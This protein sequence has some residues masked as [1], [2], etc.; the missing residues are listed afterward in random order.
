MKKQP[1]NALA[2]GLA[3]GLAAAALIS[4]SPSSPPPP[5]SPPAAAEGPR[6]VTSDSTLGKGAPAFELELLDGGRLSLAEHKG[7]HTVILDFW[8][9]WCGPCRMAM[10]VLAE[11]ASAF[12]DR[13]VKL[14]AVNLREDPEKIRAFLDRAE[15]KVAVA[16]DTKAEVAARYGVEGIPHTV[17]IDRDG[18]IAHVHVGYTP[19]LK[20]E[21]TQVLEKVLAP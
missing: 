14:Y 7:R 20:E 2:V 12:A 8:A 4:C 5:P 1:C 3:A 13:G 18:N 16:M 15:L 17:V 10:P 21:L 9:T 6:V 19:D 11:V